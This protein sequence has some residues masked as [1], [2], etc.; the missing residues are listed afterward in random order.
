[1]TKLINSTREG[2]LLGA[3]VLATLVIASFGVFVGGTD[4]VTAAKQDRPNVVVIM[5]DDQFTTTLNAMPYT[6]SRDDWV[7]FDNTIVNTALCCPSRATLLTGLT[8]DHTGIESNSETSLFKDQPTIADWLSD[9]GYET[10]FIGKYFNKFPWGEPDDY[11]PHGWDYWASYAGKQGYYDYRL[12]DN[13]LVVD[14]NGLKSYSTDVFAEKA[15]E[16][17]DSTTPGR[18]FFS[19][20]SFFGPHSPWTPPTR[21]A[22]AK[23]KKIRETPAFLEEDVSDKPRWIRRMPEP[24]AAKMRENRTRHQRALLAVDDAIEAVFAALEAKG[25]LENTI[26][27]YTS[28]HGISMGEHRYAQKT[29]GYEICS[30]VPLLVRVPGIDGRRERAL[31]GN[32]DFAPTI[33]DYAGIETGEPVDGR[34]LRPVLEQARKRLHKG[35]YLHRAQGQKN[36]IFSGLRTKRWKYVSYDKVGE[37]ELY[38]LRRDPDELFNLISTGRRKWDRKATVLAAKLRRIRDTPPKIR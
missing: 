34:S 32:I 25:E 8:S 18:P 7:R 6:R 24:D 35:I 23:V 31:V 38:N 5:A 28:D 30:R 36:R 33:A 2:K 9:A 11:V 14:E 37:Q 29:C 12:N 20:I 26:V 19:L 10:G 13:G 27:L 16:F 3:A 1:M 17:I 22:D 4:E 15:V 21:Y